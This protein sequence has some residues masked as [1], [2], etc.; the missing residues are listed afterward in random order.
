MLIGKENN[1]LPL[2][3]SVISMESSG[4]QEGTQ[5]DIKQDTPILNVIIKNNSSAKLQLQ[6]QSAFTFI[7]NTN[8]IELPSNSE[9]KLQIKTIK[10]LENL[11]L[12]FLVLNALITPD[13][14]PLI[15][16]MA[17]I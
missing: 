16:L 4:Y 13:K 17:K 15:S 9:I 11:Q 8:L 1:L 10:K 7:K 3:E 12:D 5:V 14:N 2:L 6:N